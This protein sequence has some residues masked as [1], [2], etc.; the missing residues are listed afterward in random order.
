MHSL[1]FRIRQVAR[2]NVLLR[3]WRRSLQLR[4]VGTT[5]VASGMVVVLLGLVVLNQIADGL[6]RSQR[7]AAIAETSAG[8]KY[9]QGQLSVLG[10]PR[11]PALQPTLLNVGRFLSDRGG[12]GSLY[13]VLIFPPAGDL[14]GVAPADV[15]L[16]IPADL[17]L[18]TGRLQQGYAYTQEPTP[19]G[20]FVPALVVGAPVATG[21]GLF[22]LY[23]VFPLES[24]AQTISLVRRTLLTTG[25]LL[26]LLLAAIAALVTR[27]VVK[28]VRLAARI[29]ERLAAG[30]LQ[31]R[32]VVKGEDDL[33]LLATSFNDMAI[34]LQRQFARLEE[35]SRMQRRF[36]SDVS[37]ELRTPLTTV[38]M[39]ADVL[40]AARADFAPEIARSAE[41]LLAEVE[42]FESLLTDLLEISRHDAGFAVLDPEPTDVQALTGR[43]VDALAPVAAHFGS[44]LVVRLPEERVI[45]EVDPRRVERVLRNLLGNALEH[46]EA[47]PVEVTL[48][49]G[50]E[51]IAITVR[52][53][54]VGLRPDDFPR[55]F[56]R[57]WRADPSRTRQVG[58]TGLGLSISLED[59]RL[60]GGWLQVWGALGRGAQFRLTLPL[61]RGEVLTGSPLPLEPVED[62]P[63]PA[64]SAGG[65][66]G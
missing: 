5:L 28:P 11:D 30:L 9:A 38:R 37:H 36:T 13:D 12:S 66:R 4:I 57:F 48:A 18:L 17:R 40:H 60:H 24:Q 20:H 59:A 15:D 58:G 19:N 25:L 22:E 16:T 21:A 45:A 10:G 46:G 53:H 54:G 56:H 2:R 35:L 51:A 63:K 29:A 55:V 44:E 62:E 43:V 39:A 34:S 1:L 33:A 8:L 23:Y 49:S 6:V 47:R 7:K 50:D 52:D 42:R 27:Q 65:S 61:R 64:A 26:V 14:E 32:M 41:L 31:E 3:Y